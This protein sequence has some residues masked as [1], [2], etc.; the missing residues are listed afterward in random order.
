MRR[1]LI[2]GAGGKD[3]SGS[4][5][6]AVEAKDS[7][8][9]IAYAKVIDLISEGEI[10]GLVDGL[11][12][13][14]LD[15]TP[16]QNADGSYNFTGATFQFRNGSQS[17]TYMPGF[18][19]VESET[20]VSTEV[21][22][23]VSVTR[24]ISN[25]NVNRVR[26]TVGIPQLSSQN[27]SNG[28]IGGTSV[29]I[30]VD[31]QSNGGGFVTQLLGYEWVTDSITIASLTATA[32]VA[33]YGIGFTLSDGSTDTSLSGY[34]VSVEYRLVGAGSWTVFGTK[35]LQQTSTISGSGEFEVVTTGLPNPVPVEITDLPSGIYEVRVVQTSGTGVPVM[36]EARI[37]KIT[38]QD[39]ISGKTSSRY[40]RSYDI[41]LT[42]SAPWDVR[43]RRLTEDSTSQ[44][45]QN[46]TFWDS[47][48]EIIDTKL[49]FPN[50]A[51]AGL[52]I[53]SGQFQSIP[54]RGYDAKLLRVKIP[55]NYNPLTRVYTGSWDGT[56]TVAWTDNP[57]WCFYDMLTNS[58]YGLGGFVGS[59]Q[60]DKWS[61]YTIAQYCDGLVDNGFGGTEPRLTCNLYL[62]TRQD[63][64][65]V[66]NDMASIFRAMAFWSSGSITTIQ[67][68]PATPNYLYTPANV[69]DGLFT[70]AGSSVKARHTVALV[71]WND[72]ADMYKTKV[73]YVED[74]DGIAQYGVVETQIAAIGCTSRG[75]ANRAGKWLILSERL[76]TDVVSFKVGL[77]GAIARPGQIVKI[78]DPGRAGVRLG[79]RIL[80][81][82]TSVVTL[83]GP[84]TL[85]PAVTYTLA[86]VNQS[87]GVTEKTVTTG[88]GTVSALTVSPA[89]SV[90]PDP[91][92]IWI[93]TS[94]AV[95]YQEFRVVAVTE[96][97]KHQ[98]AITA[99]KS[100]QSKYAAVESG[101]KLETR[102][103]TRL[104]TKPSTPDNGQVGEY[105]Y[106]AATDLKTMV[107]VTVDAVDGALTYQFSYRRDEGNFIDMT[108][109]NTPSVQINDAQPG[110]YTFKVIATNSIGYKSTPYVFAATVY[111]KSL[112]PVDVTN[113]YLQVQG[114]SGIL[115]WDS[116]PDLDVRLGGKI[117][118]RYS[119][120]TAGASWSTSLPLAEFSGA[121]TSG[122][123]PL[124][125][126]TYLAKALDTSGIY[127][128]N[129]VVLSTTVPALFTYNAVATTSQNPTFGGTKIDMVVSSGRLQLDQTFYFDTIVDLDAMLDSLDNGIKESGSYLFDSPIDIGGVY[130]CRVTANIGVLSYDVTNFVDDWSSVDL[131]SD[132]DGLINGDTASVVLFISTTQDNPYGGPLWTDWRQFSVGEYTARGFRFR[133]DVARGALVSQ[134]VSVF[135]LSVTVD[136]PDR[137]EGDN[138]VAVPSGGMT[139]T[140]AKEF[141]AVPAVA[142]TAQNM[143]TGDYCSIT[144]KTTAGFTIQFLNS[145]GSGIARTM[146]WIAKGYGYKT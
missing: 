31:I 87:G 3:A 113:L 49:R 75:Q 145:A 40:Q 47:Y 137:V 89:Y 77:D 28:D 37:Y 34:V 109:S 55:S 46:K 117:V 133:L 38:G 20:A 138:G 73:E 96:D 63:A 135:P 100:D 2:R 132:I 112:P 111:G 98:F 88:A 107:T 53:D 25:A 56:F 11:K 104:S 131:I 71:S 30:A 143:T 144:S 115:S 142:V 78:A 116:H 51:L 106:E 44:A 45:L 62:Q 93:L 6:V 79:G 101:L 41:P 10:E 18:D 108:P 85:A 42:G 74:K 58:R 95:A 123:V 4:G 16:V 17:Q 29:Q 97:D 146:D 90:A 103:F 99:L 82:T 128:N 12:S 140:F 32:S 102:N 39:K 57:A 35:T 72:P 60:V 92:S 7:L 118:V 94:S 33:A 8:R 67:D 86:I 43:V 125:T 120:S 139:V 15:G 23:A 76:E 68:S 105:L 24:T 14:Y 52:K 130:P 110:D 36:S 50:S 21:K 136:V 22:K 64:Y 5:R 65:K 141:F 48:T 121:A 134:Q 84:V 19:A 124:L 66:I 129:A 114:G 69:I 126:G 27:T 122:S 26:V 59:A 83:D 54:T 61:L 119:A 70:Y 127:S 9:S 81:A 91:M 80:S 1:T 13:V